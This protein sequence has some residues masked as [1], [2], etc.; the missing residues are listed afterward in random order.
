MKITHPGTKPG[1]QVYGYTNSSFIFSF[2][3]TITDICHLCTS[4]LS[5]RIHYLTSYMILLSLLKEKDTNYLETI[6]LN[7]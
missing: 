6:W 3:K 1:I 4:K 2:I 7:I 5:I